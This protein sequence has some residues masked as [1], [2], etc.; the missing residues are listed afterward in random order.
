[1]TLG[2]S[3]WQAAKTDQTN[4]AKFKQGWDDWLKTH[5]EGLIKDEPDGWPKCGP[6]F[7]KV[8]SAPLRRLV[9]KMLHPQPELRIGVRDALTTP[10]VKA[11]ECCSNERCEDA[12]GTST[13]NS[14]AT[15]T[16]TSN[17]TTTAAAAVN[18]HSGV[19]VVDATSKSSVKKTIVQKKHNH[20]PPREH[21]MPKALHY[22]FDMGDGYT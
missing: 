15:G 3:P 11:I 8:D 6:L 4:Y 14:V 10:T 21:R 17:A 18:I 9:L 22:R 12:S 19:G 1:M 7:G 2:G 20:L 5:P 13:P 16:T